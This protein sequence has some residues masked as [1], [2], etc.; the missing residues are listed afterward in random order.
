MMDIIRETAQAGTNAYDKVLKHAAVQAEAARRALLSD[1]IG[2]L[3]IDRT[4]NF[5]GNA[6]TAFMHFFGED[7]FMEVNF[8][9]FMELVQYVAK[10]KDRKDEPFPIL[11]AH[12]T[13]PG[14]RYRDL[15]GERSTSLA[16]IEAGLPVFESSVSQYIN[17]GSS[18]APTDA[19][20]SVTK[21]SLGIKGQVAT[22]KSDILVAHE[23]PD[24]AN[25]VVAGSLPF[26]TSSQSGR[27]PSSKTWPN[28]PA[29]NTLVDRLSSDVGMGKLKAIGWNPISRMLR[30]L[31]AQQLSPP[32]EGAENPGVTSPAYQLEFFEALAAKLNL[33]QD[34]SDKVS[35][36]RA[37]FY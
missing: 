28:T 25:I 16:I 26:Y 21:R 23:I 14:T 20:A 10:A 11:F 1:K 19:T 13:E 6:E 31:T 17:N 12:Q 2:E 18:E 3:G 34:L 35:A 8:R 37:S 24:P 9:P 5:E 32:Y 15:S 4:I 29:L 22:V 33:D 7:A 27:K 30:S 36:I